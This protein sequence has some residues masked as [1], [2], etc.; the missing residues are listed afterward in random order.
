MS[1]SHWLTSAYLVV[2]VC[3]CS[4]PADAAKWRNALRPEGTR[5]PAL[6]LAV[7]GQTDYVIVV[8]SAATGPVAGARHRGDLRHRAGLGGAARY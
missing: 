6:A 7:D 8:P 5:A 4:A 1:G 2:A 3:L